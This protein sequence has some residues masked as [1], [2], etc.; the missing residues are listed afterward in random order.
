MLG[1][2]AHE[3]LPCPAA[4]VGVVGLV[5]SVPSSSRGPPAGDRV[6]GVSGT[7]AASQLRIQTLLEGVETLARPMRSSAQ[8]SSCWPSLMTYCRCWLTNRQRRSSRSRGA[9][10][11]RTSWLGRARADGPGRCSGDRLP[12][13]HDVH[14]HGGRPRPWFACVG[15]TA[16]L[17][18][19]PLAEALVSNGG[20]PEWIDEAVSARATDAALSHGANHRG[21]WSRRPWTRRGPQASK[22]LR[23]SWP[24]LTPRST[25]TLA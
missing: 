1:V 21:R 9:A 20:T 19:R 18:D 2:P 14:R 5:A 13:G 7:S 12:P 3:S 17:A 8:T 16:L 22:T 10:H 23:L 6:V 25:R 15:L 4:T 24:L 11:Q